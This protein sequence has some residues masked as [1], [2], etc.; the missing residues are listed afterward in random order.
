ML[1]NITGKFAAT[2]E[3]VGLCTFEGAFQ[4]QKTIFNTAPGQGIG[5]NDVTFNASSSNSL[6]KGSVV[7][8]SALT[9]L[10]LIKF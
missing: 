8:P 9:S 4:K 10:V 7:Q 3:Y 2:V 6:Y 1:P 5:A